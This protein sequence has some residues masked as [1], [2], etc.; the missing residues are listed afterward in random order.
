MSIQNRVASLFSS[1]SFRVSPEVFILLLTAFSFGW[2][3]GY[4]VYEGDQLIYFPEILQKLDPSLFGRDILFGPGGFTLFDDFIAAGVRYGGFDMFSF[5]FLV[6]FAMR[7]LYFYGIYRIVF[8]FTGD[9]TFSMLSPLVFLSGFVIYGTGMRTIAPMLLPKYIAIAS[10]LLGLAFLFE[11]RIVASSFLLGLGF[12]FHPTGPIPFLV[13][14]CVSLLFDRIH[15]FSIKTLISAVIPLVFL[16]TVYLFVPSGGGVGIL[17]VIDQA[18]REV[19]LRRDSYYFLTTWYYPNSAP[20]YIAAS[21]FFLLL[22]KKELV[23]IFADI[24]KRRFLH[25]CFFVPLG[26]AMLSVFLADFSGSAFVTQLSLG[27]SLIM[28]KILFNGLFVYYVIR[29]IASNPRDVFYNFLLWGV[30]VSFMV[31]EKVAPVFLPALMFA[32][33]VRMI[34]LSKFATVFS[35][36]RKRVATASVFVATVL[37]VTHFASLH[38]NDGFFDA[39]KLVLPLAFLGA[40]LGM[41][42]GVRNLVGRWSF[43][44]VLAVIFF[45]ALVSPTRFSIQPAGASDPV[46][47]EV[48]EWIEA[49]TEKT[50]LFLTEPFS[51]R[52]GEVR[53]MCNRGLFA[54]RKDGGQ[55]VFDREYALEWNRRYDIIKQLK[56]DYS[57]E[58]LSDISF[59]YSVDYLLSDES[60]NLAH[61]VFDNGRYYVYKL[62]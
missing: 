47:L 35:F 33:T 7:F 29:Y 43:S 26:L 19:I 57:P 2:F 25:L 10:S 54:T 40:F 52:G 31:N 22:V 36:L 6:S 5:L 49:N 3:L 34:D 8:Y 15:L 28:W 11:K 58:L 9:K 20:I 45:G 1:D 53:M 60:L 24:Q 44:F 42:A 48:C 13:V 32:W 17:D 30:V 21:I 39:F 62:R 59:K 61:K 41:H 14:F 37:V 12:L 27:R 23:S 56:A 18:W 51:S 38:D 46:F 4:G 50:S 55:V 16:Y